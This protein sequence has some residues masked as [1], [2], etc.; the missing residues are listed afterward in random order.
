MICFWFLS[1]LQIIYPGSACLSS[2]DQMVF[3][4][5]SFGML[6]SFRL[7]TCQYSLGSWVW[8]S[9]ICAIL[10]SRL[11]QVVSMGVVISVSVRE[12]VLVL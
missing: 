2:V 3:P 8:A 12:C 10:P 6:F 1:S 9:I 7:W 11:L 4:I 5:K